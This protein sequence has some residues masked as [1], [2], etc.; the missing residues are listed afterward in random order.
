MHAARERLPALAAA[1]WWGSLSVVGFVAVP[2]L[3]KHL[4]LPATAAYIASQL[5]EAQTMISIACSA[6]LF[7][8]SKRKYAESEE[9][10]ARAAMVFIIGGLLM[11]LLLQYGAAP[12]ILAARGS[13]TWLGAGALMYL[14]QWLCALAVLWRILRR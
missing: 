5:I 6:C 1:L 9:E 7:L 12:R 4:P 14:L 10:W 13:L 8:L 11:A 3:Y 2:L